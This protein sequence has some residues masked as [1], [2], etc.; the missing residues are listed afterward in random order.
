M[1]PKLLLRIAAALMLLHTI[2][3]TLGALT[4]KEAPNAAIA[5][6]ITEMISNRFDFMGRSVTIALFFEGYGITMIFVL[7]LVSVCLWLFSVDTESRLTQRLTIVFA[8]FLIAVSITEFIYFFPLAASFSLLAG[9]CSLFAG[10]QK[11][12][13]R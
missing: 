12:S 9:I 7:L 6:V 5:R 10:V 1:K 3:H 8:V 4:W 2:G 11:K 13:A